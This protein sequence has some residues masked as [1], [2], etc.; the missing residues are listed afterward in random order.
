M[1]GWKEIDTKKVRDEEE[2]LD[3]VAV[4]ELR[5]QCSPREPKNSLFHR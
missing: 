3:Q 1:T 5:P 2:S 4:R